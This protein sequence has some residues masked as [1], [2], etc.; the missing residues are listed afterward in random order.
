[1]RTF[2]DPQQ[3][4]LD[5][6][7]RDS[8]EISTN[9]KVTTVARQGVGFPITVRNLLPS[10]T[11][12]NTNAVRVLLTFESDNA[13][14]LTVRPLDVGVVNAGE[15]FSGRGQVDA[16]AN[17][18]V[19]VVAQLTTISGKPVGRPVTINVTATQAGTTGWIIALAA[20]IVLIGSTA[21]R[22]RQVARE[23]ARYGV[24]PVADDPLSSSPPLERSPETLD[25]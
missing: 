4:S 9:P 14:R 23:R 15:H 18:T 8:I 12:P 20:G 19:R 11:D 10:T 2:L 7:L 24:P 25:V 17:G 13:L 21:L 22:I 6:I 16:K 3:K 1:M 5:L